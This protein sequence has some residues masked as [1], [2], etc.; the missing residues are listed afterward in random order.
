MV[1]KLS[2]V[3]FSVVFKTFIESFLTLQEPRSREAGEGYSSPIFRQRR[4]EL[5]N[6]PPAKP[7]FISF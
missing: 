5:R 1:R 6:E 2:F 7:L 4:K 3:E